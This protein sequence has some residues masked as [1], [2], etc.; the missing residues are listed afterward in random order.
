MDSLGI[1]QS[2]P[3]IVH[4]SCPL[5][6]GVCKAGKEKANN[7]HIRSG[8]SNQTMGK[9]ICDIMSDPKNEHVVSLD[10]GRIDFNIYDKHQFTKP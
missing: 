9:L 6:H 8:R 4:V 7:R 10:E 5:L 2:K 3:K 1:N